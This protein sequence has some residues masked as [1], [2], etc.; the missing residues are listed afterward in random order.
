MSVS[1]QRSEGKFSERP[2]F[3]LDF[4]MKNIHGHWVWATFICMDV[5]EA[6]EGISF[7]DHREDDA[8]ILKSEMTEVVLGLVL[9]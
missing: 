4:A 9:N 1:Y 6:K 2:L 5:C 3:Q 8:V 7:K